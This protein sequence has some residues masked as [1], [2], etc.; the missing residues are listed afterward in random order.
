MALPLNG[1][2]SV[3]YPGTHTL[4]PWF[5]RSTWLRSVSEKCVQWERKPR[6]AL[7]DFSAQLFRWS[8]GKESTCQCGR[9][10]RRRLD[11]WAEKIPWRR[12][13][14][15]TPVFLPGESHGQRNLVGYSPWSHK[16]SDMTEHA[17]AQED[18]AV[19]ALQACLHV[20]LAHVGGA[21]R[22]VMV[23]QGG[24]RQGCGHFW[25]MW[26]ETVS[27]F[28]FLMALENH[29]WA[30]S[31]KPTRFPLVSPRLSAWLSVVVIRP[32]EGGHRLVYVRV[33]T[34]PAQAQHRPRGCEQWEVLGTGLPTE[35]LCGSLARVQRWLEP[36]LVISGTMFLHIKNC[37]SEVS[38]ENTCCLQMKN[39]SWEE[40]LVGLPSLEAKKRCHSWWS[41]GCPRSELLSTFLP[42]YHFSPGSCSLAPW[43]THQAGMWPDVLLA[44]THYID[45]NCLAWPW[46]RDLVGRC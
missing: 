14:Q 38:R 5:W 23:E 34:G 24:M 15:P 41:V 4:R 35:V 7:W 30:F 9:Y 16:G 46:P 27:P 10:R 21:R 18:S 12:K 40:A 37:K 26:L 33:S 13:W 39:T 11:P 45:N 43:G 42:C 19:S 22:N 28:T 3:T 31:L 17:S 36:A 1:R 29:P 2:P 6:R 32:A 25:K 8:N 44:L 20:H